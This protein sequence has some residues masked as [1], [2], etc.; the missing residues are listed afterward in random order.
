MIDITDLSD[1]ALDVVLAVKTGE[2][3]VT[4]D[5]LSDDERRT[6]CKALGIEMPASWRP[7]A[8]PATGHR[9]VRRL[10]VEARILD[11]QDDFFED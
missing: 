9:P 8:P 5:H 1:A 6:V 4:V 2:D 7:Y 3:C 10:D 11:R